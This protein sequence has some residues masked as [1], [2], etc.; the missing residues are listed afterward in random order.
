M[1][2]QIVYFAAQKWIASYGGNRQTERLVSLGAFSRMVDEL[3]CIDLPQKET[4]LS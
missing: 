1:F 2:L 4:T 3:P